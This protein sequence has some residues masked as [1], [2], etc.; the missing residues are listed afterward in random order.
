MYR[1]GSDPAESVRCIEDSGLT[2]YGNVIY[3]CTLDHFTSDFVLH[4]KLSSLGYLDP[5]NIMLILKI[6]IFEGIVTYI[7]KDSECW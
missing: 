7:D 4:F 2:V 6:V 1:N 3:T 5:V